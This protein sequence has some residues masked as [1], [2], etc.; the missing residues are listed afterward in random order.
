LQHQ[1]FAMHLFAN[2]SS[3][4]LPQKNIKIKHSECRTHS[5]S[6]ITLEITFFASFPIL[7]W[8]YRDE[9]LNHD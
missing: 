2:D 7:T 9:A 8:F 1:Q 6:C 5:S 3:N 4:T